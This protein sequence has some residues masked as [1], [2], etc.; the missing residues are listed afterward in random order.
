MENIKEIREEDP[1]QHRVAE[2]NQ[3]APSRLRNY[4]VGFG[5]ANLVFFELTF[6]SL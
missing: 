2:Q 5:Y 4:V 1:I 3:T 6:C